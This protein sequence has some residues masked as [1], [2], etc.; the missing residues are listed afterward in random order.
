MG[1]GLDMLAIISICPPESRP[2]QADNIIQIGTDLWTLWEQVDEL[3][4]NADGEF[5]ENDIWLLTWEVYWDMD[6]VVEEF[7]SGCIDPTTGEEEIIQYTIYELIE[8]ANE[9]VAEDHQ[10]LGEDTPHIRDEQSVRDMALHVTAMVSGLPIVR[11]GQDV[12]NAEL[13]PFIRWR[14]RLYGG[15][16]RARSAG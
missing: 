3:L 2:H 11:Y 10:W 9:M 12:F 7:G 8:N 14:S 15:H 5:D 16:W 6:E 4:L 13:L 1:L